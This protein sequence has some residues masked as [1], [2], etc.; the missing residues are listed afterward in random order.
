MHPDQMFAIVRQR[1]RDDHAAADR[2]RLA[3]AVETV[4]P[5]QGPPLAPVRRHRPATI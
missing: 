5:A 1:H 2:H 4:K 3:R